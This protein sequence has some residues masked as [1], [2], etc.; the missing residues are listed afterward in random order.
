VPD[1]VAAAAVKQLFHICYWLAYTY[2]RGSRPDPALQFTVPPAPAA[3]APAPQSAEKL[4][5]LEQS[6]AE[7]DEKLTE[8]LVDRE[9]LDQELQ[10]LRAEVAQARR[11][12]AARPDTHDYS[13]AE[14]RDLFV[15]LLLHEAG[16][17]LDQSRDREYEVRGMPNRPGT[18]KV[19]Y[20]LWGDDGRPLGLVE[21][22]RTRRDAREGKRQAELYADCLEQ[23]FGR[24]PVIF[25]SNGYE[26]WLWDDAMYP[27]RPVQGFYTRDELEYLI[28][29]RA[30]RRSLAGAPIDNAIVERH[31]QVHAIRSVGEAFGRDFERKALLVMATGAGK[32]R[33]VIALA[34]LLIGCNWVK[35]VLFLADRV[36]L[37]NQAAGA[38]KRHLPASSPVNLVTERNEEGRVYVS[39][40]PTMMSLINEMENGRRR[41][42]PGHFDLVV[43][44]EAHRSVYQK[45]RAIFE[46]FDSLLVGL[47]ATPRDEIDHNT[48]SLFDL[49]DRVPTDAYELEDAIKDGFLVPFEAVSVPIKF[50]REGITYDDL[51]AEE[52]ERWDALEWDDDT[53]AVPD[54]VEAS[55]LNAWLF[56]EDTVDKVLAHLMTHGITV[57]GGDRI[58]KTIIFAKN[59]EH[60]EFIVERFDANY[61][62]LRGHFCSAIHHRMSYAQSLIDD[63]SNPNKA[64]HIAVSVDML[65]TGIDIPEIVNLVFFK[66]V[67]SRTKFWQMV[68]R[69]T[70][71]CP[72]LFGPGEDKTHFYILD[73]CGNLEFF[74]Q[75]PITVEGRAAESLSKRLFTSRL[76]LIAE[77]DRRPDAAPA[78][79][80][81]ALRADTAVLL[82]T[83]VAS[84]DLR[85]FVVRPK[86][87]VVERFAGY[88]A[89]ADLDEGDL[90]D[91]ATEVAGLPSNREAEEEEAKR[92]DL[93]MLTLQLALLRHQA[94][95]P[96]LRDQVIEIAQLL[97]E[98]PNIPM[99]A[100][101]LPL[102]E[103][104]QSPDWWQDVTVAMLEQ[105][106]KKLRSLVG[107]IE[108]RKR[109]VLFTDFRDEIGE[110]TEIDLL[111][112]SSP[113]S[114]GAFRTKIQA[115]LRKHEDQIAIYRLRMNRPL[116]AAD[117]DQLQQMLIESGIADRDNLAQAAADAEGLGLFV[118]SLV[119]LHRGAAKEAFADFLAGKTLNANQ[120]HFINLIIDHL[121]E[122][123]VMSPALLYESPFTDISPHGPEG[124]FPEGQV[125]ELVAI[126]HQVRA[127]ALAG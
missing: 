92:F 53:G 25:Y 52:Q 125:D 62:K 32:T 72:D 29:R 13:E 65:D 77:L 80:L 95:F 46:Y 86:R 59:K 69:G 101:Q 89:W 56:N 6:L 33:T 113:L 112:I 116:T 41:F 10:R 37:V 38:F 16:W 124:L 2:A 126:L 87:A 17:P 110:A 61:P 98:Y 64:P 108:K 120:I 83:E 76:E 3:P 12:A 73:Y 55:A 58:G 122:R 5:Q 103:E 18:G 75:H 118:R 49:E 90:H 107:F 23:Q 60:A 104:L 7:R 93:L 115:Y 4:Q 28:Q 127:T 63:F 34:D 85:N 70:R 79:D 97:E 123:G 43:I 15:D 71:L 109:K 74:G 66:P 19:D 27:P 94:R 82:Q 31:Y 39:T 88:D 44:D 96:K 67:R 9:Q 114:T 54:R 48:Y 68:G 105:V 45:Y 20:V 11:E 51:S 40:Y 47:T 50:Q 78:G 8:I 21:T 26:H 36:A 100:A 42:G 106:R 99:V 91:L 121:T 102:I 119:G 81:D 35:R 57:A 24:R 30:T 84:M 111:G 22:K 1:S 117:L 14:T